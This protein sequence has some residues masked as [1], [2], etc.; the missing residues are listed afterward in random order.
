MLSYC[1]LACVSGS[2]C[3]PAYLC[4]PTYYVPVLVISITAMGILKVIFDIYKLFQL[5][6]LT[7]LFP[8]SHSTIKSNLFSI[9]SFH[10]SLIYQR[11]SFFLTYIP[12]K[13]GLSR[14]QSWPAVAFMRWT[15]LQKL[16]STVTTIR[17]SNTHASDVVTP[18]DPTRALVG[19]RALHHEVLKTTITMAAIKI[20]ANSTHRLTTKGVSCQATSKGPA[21]LLR[22]SRKECATLMDSINRCMKELP[23]HHRTTRRSRIL[24]WRWVVK[25]VKRQTDLQGW[26]KKTL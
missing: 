18:M 8:S 4:L 9:T 24:F 10:L 6:C 15:K 5:C 20:N 1:A 21:S 13:W 19:S 23:L 14:P 26:W 16:R 25:A 22:T 11:I 3:N 12:W 2:L 17:H 7:W